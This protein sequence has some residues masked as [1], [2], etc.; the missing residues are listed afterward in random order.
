MTFDPGLVTRASAV[1]VAFRAPFDAERAVAWKR[2]VVVYLR[3]SLALSGTQ[4]NDKRTCQIFLHFASLFD[5]QTSMCH[6]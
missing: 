5:T 3:H 2:L 6:C 1:R 4:L